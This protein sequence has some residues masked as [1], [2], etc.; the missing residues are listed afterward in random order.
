[1]AKEEVK[2]DFLS[3][4]V[5][6]DIKTQITDKTLMNAELLKAAAEQISTKEKKVKI[7]QAASILADNK[8]ERC[9]QLV[10]V[11]YKRG[12]AKVFTERLKSLT[13]LGETFNKGTLSVRDY[14][15]KEQEIED[16]Y[17]TNLKELNKETALLIS[18]L[19]EQFGSKDVKEYFQSGWGNTKTANENLPDAAVEDKDDKTKQTNRKVERVVYDAD[20]KVN[21]H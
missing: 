12:E 7:E 6:G 21:R 8:F 3:L 5:E 2:N 9:R 10:L 13:E 1:M 16:K 4:N 11:R 20:Y 18:Q 19:Q 17:N 15:I 14:A